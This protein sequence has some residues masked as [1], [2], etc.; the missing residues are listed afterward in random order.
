MVLIQAATRE[1]VAAGVEA[2]RKR[3]VEGEAGEAGLPIVVVEVVEEEESLGLEVVGDFK[4]FGEA[5]EVELGEVALLDEI[6]EVGVGV[7]VEEVTHLVR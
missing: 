4:C 5:E 1:L 6:I 2:I 7:E 3:L